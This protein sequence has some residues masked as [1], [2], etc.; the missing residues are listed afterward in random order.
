MEANASLYTFN[1]EQ[2]GR[3]WKATI[4]AQTEPNDVASF[5][6]DISNVQ[7]DSVIKVIQD[8]D[9]NTFD[10]ETIDPTN[11][12]VYK[13][14]METIDRSIV[15]YAV[16]ILGQNLTTEVNGGSFA[17]TETHMKVREE[18]INSDKE[19]LFGLLNN[20]LIKYYAAINNDK[21]NGK[22]IFN[23]NKNEE[24][25]QQFDIIDRAVA[26]SQAL[27]EASELFDFKKIFAQANINF[28]K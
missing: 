14:Y 18:I 2:N 12:T 16:T 23:I 22:F 20:D 7:K 8:R 1:N 11:S 24:M 17:A 27:A 28:I 10:V 4:P 5:L 9:G 26:S 13:S 15:D 6:T 25:I 19:T 3:I 21:Y